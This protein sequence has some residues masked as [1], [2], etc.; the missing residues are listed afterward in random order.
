MNRESVYAALFARASGA[1]EFRTISRRLRHWG[2]V[3]PIDQPALFQAQR[4]E[5]PEQQ[6]GLPAKWRLVADLYI[7]ANSGAD[8]GITPTTELNVLLDA[9][10]NA[11][12]PDPVTGVQ[13]LGGLASHC[14]ISGPIET[15]EGT[16]GEQAV[17]IVPIEILVA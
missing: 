1:G 17:A 12:A 5:T 13:T 2:D 3:A 7:Y 11:F 4:R 6:R 14:W 15:D 9:V 16:L 10:E 8:P